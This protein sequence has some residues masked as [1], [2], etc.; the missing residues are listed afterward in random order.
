MPPHQP[1]N[2][3]SGVQH[4]TATSLFFFKDTA[5]TEIYTLSLPYPLPISLTSLRLGVSAVH[6]F[7]IEQQDKF[8]SV[9]GSCDVSPWEI[10][11]KYS[12]IASHI[13]HR[14]NA[15]TRKE[16]AI[17]TEPP[18]AGTPNDGQK[19]RCSAQS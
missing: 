7:F 2:I 8:Y 17:E 9:A 6:R 3:S 5:T 1:T 12:A 15:E 10:L 16:S 13:S 14:G 18:E 19:L 4:K 11:T